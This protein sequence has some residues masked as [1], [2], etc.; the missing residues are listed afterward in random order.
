[1]ETTYYREEYGLLVRRVHDVADE[2]FLNGEWKPTDLLID[3]TM[4]RGWLDVITEAEARQL[5]PAAFADAE[6]LKP[7]RLVL[8]QPP[9]DDA[10]LV[11]WAEA[12]AAHVIGK[13]KG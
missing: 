8:A 4:G 3:F 7:Q 5:A 6:P 12:L 13:P 9:A 2:S 1:M 11:A 10:E